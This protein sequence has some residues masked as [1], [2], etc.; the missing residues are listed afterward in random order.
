[1][2]YGTKVAFEDVREIA[3]GSITANYTA[4]GAATAD[5]VRLLSINNSTDVEVYISFDG[6]SDHIRL[7]SNSFKLYDFTAN[8]VHDDG[9]FLSNRTTFY[10]KRVSGAPTLGNVW[11]EVL[12][13]E[14]GK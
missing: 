10:I 8:S 1:M 11:I 14:G 7:T 6:V 4:L 3:F 12:V 13:G 5:Y 2:A 9:F